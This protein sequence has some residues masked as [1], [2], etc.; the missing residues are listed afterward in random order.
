M[1]SEFERVQMCYAITHLLDN[2]DKNNFEKILA[3]E[4]SDNVD[5]QA[6][7]DLRHGEMISIDK[8]ALDPERIVTICTKYFDENLALYTGAFFNRVKEYYTKTNPY[9]IYAVSSDYRFHFAQVLYTKCYERLGI[10]RYDEN[11]MTQCFH[12]FIENSFPLG[13]IKDVSERFV[14]MHPQKFLDIKLNQFLEEDSGA[15]NFLTR[16]DK[17]CI[18]VSAFN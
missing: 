9:Y 7:L 6:T 5:E 2:N 11:T 18:K 8:T 4:H 10:I 14:Y 15:I 17:Q 16:V 3:F 13:R 12:E 1:N